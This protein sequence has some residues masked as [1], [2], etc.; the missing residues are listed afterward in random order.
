MLTID[1]YYIIE[2]PFVMIKYNPTISEFFGLFA[3]GVVTL[4]LF[5]IITF[6]LLFPNVH[7]K[8]KRD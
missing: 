7:I 6:K 3:G 8:V 4:M 2:M 1:M 5:T